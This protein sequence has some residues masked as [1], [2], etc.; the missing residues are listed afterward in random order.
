MGL[1]VSVCVDVCECWCG[2]GCICCYV[3]MWVFG[4]CL[5]VDVSVVMGLV[6]MQGCVLVYVGVS[7]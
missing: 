6:C 1:C 2:F 3:G 5:C 4:V 7:V